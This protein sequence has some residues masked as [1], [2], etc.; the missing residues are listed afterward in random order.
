MSGRSV[1]RGCLQHWLALIAH[2]PPGEWSVN[3]DEYGNY[4]LFCAEALM[5]DERVTREDIQA[6]R[7]RGQ[8]PRRADCP[9]LT[10]VAFRIDRPR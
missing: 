7:D 9:L 6:R 1:S 3:K 10:A 8:T 2:K 5:P 4:F